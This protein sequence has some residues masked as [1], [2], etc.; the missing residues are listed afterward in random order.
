MDSFSQQ[1]KWKL[2][3]SLMLHSTYRGKFKQCFL[4]DLK[5]QKMKSLTYMRSPNFILECTMAQVL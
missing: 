1:S 2:S 4:H 3:R 5:T